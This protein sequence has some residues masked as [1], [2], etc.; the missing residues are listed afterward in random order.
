MTYRTSVATLVPR[1]RRSD[2][3]G[4]RISAQGFAALGLLAAVIVLDQATKAWGWRHVPDAIINAGGTAS[5][6]PTLDGWYTAPRSGA[7]LDVLDCG[8][9]ILA[10]L[11]MVRRRRPVLVLGSGILMISGWSSN[12]LDRL[13][14]HHLTA[15]GSVR[16]AVDFIP[17]G[18]YFYNVADIFIVGATLVFVVALC[19]AGVRRAQSSLR[20]WLHRGTI[21]LA[22]RRGQVQPRALSSSR[23]PLRVDAAIGAVHD[24]G[25]QTTVQSVPQRTA[26]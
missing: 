19:A 23:W 16:G 3:V 17:L 24:I 18:R 13:G 2:P 14:M 15:P 7:I 6:G 9:L 26:A 22:F 10:G 1:P 11:L 20:T 25:V 5:V 4:R 8:L 21:E 12:L